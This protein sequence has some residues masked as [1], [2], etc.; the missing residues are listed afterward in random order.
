MVPDE[1]KEAV[2]PDEKFNRVMGNGYKY[3]E[4]NSR[5]RAL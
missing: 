2:I 4:S 5:I 3:E 1:L